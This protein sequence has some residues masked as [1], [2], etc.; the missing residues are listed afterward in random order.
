MVSLSKKIFI[1]VFG[2][3]RPNLHIRQKS[4]KP[5]ISWRNPE[6]MLSNWSCS[7]IHIWNIFCIKAKMF[8]AFKYFLILVT[9]AI[10]DGWRTSRKQFWK[11]TTQEPSLPSLVHI[12]PVVLEKKIKMWILHGQRRTMTDAKWWQKLVLPL[13]RWTKSNTL[14]LLC[15]Y[16][17]YKNLVLWNNLK[18]DTESSITIIYFTSSHTM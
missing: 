8:Y 13:A 2:Q 12:C 15:S 3:N 18:Y 7:Y 11:G 6:Y 10:L 5:Y 1:W 4:A 9:V 17:I 14:F 16:K